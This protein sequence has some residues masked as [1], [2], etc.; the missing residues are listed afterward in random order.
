MCAVLC[1][2]VYER[3]PPGWAIISSHEYHEDLSQNNNLNERQKFY[4]EEKEK[5]SLEKVDLL[6]TLPLPFKIKT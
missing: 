4:R 6:Y 3:L 5:P 2:C 1:E